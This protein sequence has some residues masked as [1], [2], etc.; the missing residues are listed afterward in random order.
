MYDSQKKITPWRM[1]KGISQEK[2]DEWDQGA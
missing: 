2:K 1:N